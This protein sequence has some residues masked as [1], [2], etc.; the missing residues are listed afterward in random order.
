MVESN[1]PGV[2]HYEDVEEIEGLMVVE[3]G[4]RFS[5]CSLVVIG[6]GPPCQGVSGRSCLFVHV[7]RVRDLVKRHFTWAAVHVL[8]ESV[9]SMDE[10]VMSDDFGSQPVGR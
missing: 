8:M 3:W 7:S 9:S 10:A 1:Y 6:A 5:Q 2:L 4:L